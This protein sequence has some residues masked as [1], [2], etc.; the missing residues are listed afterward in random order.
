MSRRWSKHYSVL[1]RSLEMNPMWH[2]HLR[3]NPKYWYIYSFLLHSYRSAPPPTNEQ[4]LV[5]L[6]PHITHSARRKALKMKPMWSGNPKIL[7]H[8]F[9]PTVPKIQPIAHANPNRRNEYD[10][11]P[12]IH[13]ALHLPQLMSLYWS[14]HY[15]QWRRAQQELNEWDETNMTCTF[16]RQ[17]KV[18][19]YLLIPI[20]S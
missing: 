4:T 11:H 13:I 15:S 6:A 10:I 18:L 14:K 2:A 5:L 1:K 20:L 17:P 8:L 9:V 3:G 19:I 12:Y 16:A 7:I